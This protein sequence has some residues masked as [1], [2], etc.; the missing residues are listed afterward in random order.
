MITALEGSAPLVISFPHVGTGLPPDLAARMTA[1]ARA[2]P[3]TDWHVEKLYAFARARGV[4]WIE[5]HLSRYVVDLNRP[6]DDG[7]LYPGQVSTGLC[8]A[9][10]FAGE[11][12]YAG[13]GPDAE[14]IAA[15]REAYW[16]PYHERLQ[17]LLAATVARHGYAVLLDAHSIESEVPRLFEGRLPDLNVGTNDGR[18]CAAGL[19]EAVLKAVASGPFSAVLNGRF[20]GGYITRQYGRIDGPVHAVQLEIGQLTYLERGKTDWQAPRAAALMAVLERM[21]DVLLDFRPA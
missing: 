4:S 21:V 6:P 12:L 5:P 11:P 19:G 1:R 8:P 9:A 3:D 14:E 17:A 7:A 15:R 2:V 18:S 10:T 20:K 16:R 13:A